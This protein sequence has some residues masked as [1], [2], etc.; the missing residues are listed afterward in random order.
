MPN[1]VYLREKNTSFMRA[2]I[3][4]ASLAALILIMTLGNSYGDQI[5]IPLW[6]KNNAKW[7]SKGQIEDPDFVKGI[8]YLIEQQIIQLPPTSA[9]SKTQT[10]IPGWIK[11]N[12]GWWANGTIGDEDFVKGIQYLIQVNILRIN[13]PQTFS[14]SSSAFAN[15]GTIPSQYTCDGNNISPP[16]TIAG[17]PVNTKSLALIVDDIDA[18]TGI[19]THWI[20]WN[21][22]TGKTQFVGGENIDFPQG[23][24]SFGKSGYHGPCPPSGPPH[25]YDFKL[26]ALDS[27]LNLDFSSTKNDLENSMNDHIIA[28]ATLIGK[29][30][31]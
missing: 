18:P 24:T 30:S 5:Q 14:I 11:N 29:Y 21:I 10:Q 26:Y 12:A 1:L 9:S 25:R 3:Y 13:P 23:I 22:P 2:R 27:S 31:R 17:V 28:Q 7:W 15:N 6:V 20:V 4:L 19:F 16:L 8:Q